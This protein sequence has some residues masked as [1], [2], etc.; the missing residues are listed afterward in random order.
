LNMMFQQVIEHYA[1][2]QLTHRSIA[3]GTDKQS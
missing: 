3:N 2:N 1:P